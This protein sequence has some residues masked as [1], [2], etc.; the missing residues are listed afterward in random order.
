MQRRTILT[1]LG[2]ALGV[3]AGCLNRTSDNR[4]SSTT[5]TETPNDSMTET[6]DDPVTEIPDGRFAGEPCPSFAD[7]VDRTV[8]WHT[9]TSESADVYLKPAE[10]V[11]TPSTDGGSVEPIDFVLHNESGEAFGLNPNAW[12]IKRRTEDGWE[13]VA[14]DVYIEPWMTLEDGETYT[15]Q[16]STAKQSTPM[17]EDSMVIVQEL[18]DGTYAFQITG[19]VGDDGDSGRQIECIALF[20]VRRQS[21]SQTRTP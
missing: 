20:D 14:P 9:T 15:W 1:T 19:I 16:L 17:S 5:T 7:S 2:T 21:T 4:S 12:A 6:P 11:Y 3:S 18:D 10:Q 13:H 8:C